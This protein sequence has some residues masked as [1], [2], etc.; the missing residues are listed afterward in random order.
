MQAWQDAG[1]EHVLSYAIS[2]ELKRGN[3]G[4]ATAG[5]KRTLSTARFIVGLHNLD[6]SID[7]DILH[8]WHEKHKE[9][10]PK[11]FPSNQVD[12]AP[13]GRVKSRLLADALCLPNYIEL[14][15]EFTVVSKALYQLHPMVVSEWLLHKLGRRLILRSNSDNAQKMACV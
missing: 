10:L 8:F 6:S 14:M 3:Y 12:V 13:D 15:S 11:L 4:S 9:Y 2:C 1:I 7:G 5:Q